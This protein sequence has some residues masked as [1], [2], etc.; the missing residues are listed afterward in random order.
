[1][2][3]STFGCG[4]EQHSTVTQQPAEVQQLVGIQQLVGTQQLVGMQP[5]SVTRQELGT[6]QPGG[7]QQAAV[8]SV[9]VEGDCIILLLYIYIRVFSG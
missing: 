4:G 5:I 7:E 3:Q 2:P 8:L 1:M 9:S 6:Q